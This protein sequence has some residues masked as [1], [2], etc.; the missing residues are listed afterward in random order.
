MRPWGTGSGVRTVSPS[1]NGSET[2]VRHG[3]HVPGPAI[4]S[5]EREEEDSLQV[6]DRL[7][8][9]VDRQWPRVGTKRTEV[10]KAEDMVGVR[11][12]EDDG[13]HAPDIFAETLRSEIRPRIDHE[14]DFRRLDINRRTASA[15]ARI[16]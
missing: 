13:V 11:V 2:T 3:V 9:A 12:G 15:I 14:C 5:I 16:G 4:L 6:R 10:V 1:E 8:R 7:L